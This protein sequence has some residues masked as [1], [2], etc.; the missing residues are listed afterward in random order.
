MQFVVKVILVAVVV[1]ISAS[2]LAFAEKGRW[3]QKIRNQTQCCH[4]VHAQR[5]YCQ[6][7]STLSCPVACR[8]YSRVI[9]IEIT[10]HSIPDAGT[11]HGI[12]VS[13]NAIGGNYSFSFQPNTQTNGLTSHLQVLG[14]G[15]LTSMYFG[16]NGLAP[17]ASDNWRPIHIRVSEIKDGTTILY[18]SDWTAEFNNDNRI[19]RLF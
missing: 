16:L 9:H 11:L 7:D 10:N 12:Y 18:D 14:G 4:P 3:I 17:S 19:H 1:S 13:G 5:P 6:L 15:D 2:S 8:V